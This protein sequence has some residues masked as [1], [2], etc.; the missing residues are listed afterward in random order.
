MVP[1]KGFDWCSIPALPRDAKR[2]CVRRPFYC[3]A[4]LLQTACGLPTDESVAA[5]HA[6]KALA[7]YRIS[8]LRL[9]HG[10]AVQQKTR[11]FSAK[12]DDRAGF[13]PSGVL[14]SIDLHPSAVWYF[15]KIRN[16]SFF[17]RPKSADFRKRKS[18]LQTVKEP[19][20]SDGENSGSFV[21]Y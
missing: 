16:V 17:D 9:E 5:F 1:G 3:Y 19:L 21:E 8:S 7:S 13:G 18:A 4:S 11:V 14:C 6:E 2:A 12:F 10:A 20:F 15:V